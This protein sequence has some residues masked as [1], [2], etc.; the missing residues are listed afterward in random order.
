MN[1]RTD[2]LRIRDIR[3]L[4]TPE[5]IMQEYPCTDDASATVAQSRAGLRHSRGS[6]IRARKLGRHLFGR[7]ELADLSD[8]KVIGTS[9][10]VGLQSA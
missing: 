8:A 5:Q 7:Y 6:R 3:E 1:I 9:V 10:H 4:S 2:D